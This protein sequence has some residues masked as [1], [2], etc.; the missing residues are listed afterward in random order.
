MMLGR[1]LNNLRKTKESFFNLNNDW[2]NLDLF[3]KN[4][5]VGYYDSNDIFYAFNLKK[6]EYLDSYSKQV[7]YEI[8]DK[9]FIEHEVWIFKNIIDKET[10][11]N[12]F[13]YK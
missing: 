3:K 10:E 13:L 7:L 4:L 2:I 12:L 5:K 6:S 1:T 11:E 8:V 9:N